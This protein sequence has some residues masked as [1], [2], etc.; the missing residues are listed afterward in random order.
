MER[1]SMILGLSF[2]AF[3]TLH[4]VVSLIG[5]ASGLIV[6]AGMI[7]GR[8]LPGWTALFLAATVLTSVTGFLFPI[9]ELLPSHVIGAIS[10]AVLAVALAALYSFRL[11]GVWRSIYIGTAVLALY[12]NV[13]V[14]VVQA[15]QKLPFLQALAPTQSE[16]PFAVA[17]LAVLAAFA[18]L[19]YLALKRFQPVP[20]TAPP[21]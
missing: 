3:T 13:F 21:A 19:G 16:P 1:R 9:S 17:H 5:I 10:L 12:L 7:G 11:S 20:R 15:F 2:S 4:V 8:R 6:L 14:G 18:L